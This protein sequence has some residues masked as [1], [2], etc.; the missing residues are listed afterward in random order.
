[1][2]RLL[3]RK[4]VPRGRSLRS[5]YKLI[6]EIVIMCYNSDEENN[7]L[8]KDV[9]LLDVYCRASNMLVRHYWIDRVFRLA[10]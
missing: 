3:N 1:M 5:V 9:F 2:I 10:C 7:R 8:F 6:M 4:R